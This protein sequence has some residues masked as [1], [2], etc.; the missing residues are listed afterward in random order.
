MKRVFLLSCLFLLVTC[1]ATCAQTLASAA[2]PATAVVSGLA[3]DEPPV[4]RVSVSLVN[5]NVM[6]TDPLGHPVHGLARDEFTVFEEDLQQAIATFHED[7]E[8][9]VS[10]GILFDVSESMKD[11]IA[12]VQ[13]AVDHFADTINPHDEVF[14]IRFNNKVKIVRDFTDDRRKLKHAVG[15]LSPGGETALYD[16]ILEGLHHLEQSKYEK[17][18]LFVITDGR[19]TKSR[20]R[21]QD[22]IAATHRS[23]ALVYGMAIG[24]GHLDK[25]GSDDSVDYEVLKN[26]AAASG[27]K[28]FLIESKR[29]RQARDA[30]NAAALAVSAELRDQYTLAYYPP[31]A[32][33]DGEFRHI[34]VHNRHHD[35]V[36][37]ARTGYITSARQPN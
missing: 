5:L 10:V 31:A 18:A 17:K 16:A 20:A 29:D 22:V 2:E 37:R 36:V 32:K 1:G 35:Y 11:K 12:R 7:A 27:A 25:N 15:Y 13:Q 23:T 33:R 9:P 4:F 34:R 26:I 14:L 3:G 24:S 30:I 19:D 21:L 6:V 8:T 28:A